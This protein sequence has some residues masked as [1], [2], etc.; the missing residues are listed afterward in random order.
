MCRSADP[1]M[2]TCFPSPS[3]YRVHQSIA[4]SCQHIH[5]RRIR[6]SDAQ[7]QGGSGQGGAARTRSARCGDEPDYRADLERDDCA[8]HLDRAEDRQRLFS[9]GAILRERDQ[10]PRNTQ[11]YPG[12]LTGSPRTRRRGVAAR[13]SRPSKSSAIQQKPTTIIFSAW[14]TFWSRRAPTISVEHR[15]PCRKR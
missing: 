7:Y 15:T 1:L 4:R 6:L 14:L 9:Y 13:T 12:Q 5:T 8:V 3:G 2:R 10:L 11:E